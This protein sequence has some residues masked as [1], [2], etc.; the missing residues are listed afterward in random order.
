[1]SKRKQNFSNKENES[2]TPSTSRNA[3]N[4]TKRSKLNTTNS[5]LMD[6][7]AVIKSFKDLLKNN[8][9]SGDYSVSGEATE[10]PPLPNLF[11]DQ[12]GRISLPLTE[13]QAQDL[14][15]VGTQAPFGLNQETIVDTKVR[16]SYQS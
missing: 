9:N 15:K 7:K 5:K 12:I 2:S 14:I 6:S 10:L 3:E 11:V 13:H 8:T 4:Q 1:M 16:D